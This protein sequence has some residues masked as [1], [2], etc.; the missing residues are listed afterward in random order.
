M[1]VIVPQSGHGFTEVTVTGTFTGESGSP[2]AGS[3]T[4]TLTQPMTN[5]DVVVPPKPLTVTLNEHGSFSVILF[6][7]DDEATVPQGAQYG[8]T[9]QV[10][11]AQPRDYC[12]L[13]SHAATPVDISTL[14]PGAPGWM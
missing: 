1:P 8:V 5:G 10:T 3:L 6:A 9:E 4:F 2:A 11:G 13:V 7:N 12:I 14:M